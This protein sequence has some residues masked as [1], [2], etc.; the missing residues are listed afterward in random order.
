ML[1]SG[2]VFIQIIK[3]EAYGQKIQGLNPGSPMTV[4]K[5]APTF[6]PFFSVSIGVGV[7]EPFPSWGG[8][9]AWLE[10]SILQILAETTQRKFERK[11]W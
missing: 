2:I 9:H 3:V 7:V 8:S 11:R 6:V 1:D 5:F 10:S 4:K